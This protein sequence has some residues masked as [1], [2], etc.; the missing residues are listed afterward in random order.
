VRRAG[1]CFVFALTGCPPFHDLT[2][3]ACTTD[4]DCGSALVCYHG[5]CGVSGSW[6]TVAV[7]LRTAAAT[8]GGV[9]VYPAQ[10]ARSATRPGLGAFSTA[11]ATPRSE[12]AAAGT[13]VLGG[14]TADVTE[15]ISGGAATPLPSARSALG[16]A[17]APGRLYAIGGHAADRSPLAE[18]LSAPV[19]SDAGLGA[20][21]PEISLPT[22]R[23]GLAAVAAGSFVYAIGGE[24]NAGLTSDVLAAQILPDGTLGPWR[25]AG[26][27][28]Y[29]RARHGA[30]AFDGNLY[31]AAG[32]CG[33][34][35]CPPLRLPLQSD[36]TLGAPLTL[37]DFPQRELAGVVIAGG[38]LHVIGGRTGDGTV[39]DE[40]MSL[41][42]DESGSSGWLPQLSLPTVRFGA[43]AAVLPERIVVIDGGTGDGGLAD[44]GLADAGATVVALPVSV[45]VLG[46]ASD[47]GG[48]L[49]E[50]LE[51]AVSGE[52]IGPWS[53]GPDV[54]ETVE[55]ASAVVW[56]GA[57]YA[58]AGLDHAA[59]RDTIY[60]TEPAVDGGV[61]PWRLAG[62]TPAP[63]AGFG[64]LAWGG[65]L[66]LFGGCSNAGVMNGDCLSI[67]NV[68]V[69]DFLSDGGVGTFRDAGHLLI[70]TETPPMAALDGTVY[71]V[72]GLQ[73]WF[74]PLEDVEK[75]ALLP[76]SGALGAFASALPLPA[77]GLSRASLV[78]SRGTL[79]LLGGVADDYQN[80]VLLGSV[81]GD[82]TV[83][84]WNAAPSSLPDKRADFVALGFDDA[85]FAVG[86]CNEDG[87]NHPFC[88]NLL[89]SVPV[90]RILEDGGL[91][92]FAPTA[93]DI[94]WARQSLSAGTLAG[95]VIAY[96]GY[97]GNVHTVTNV[98]RLHGRGQLGPQQPVSPAPADVF[99]SDGQWLFS[100][101]A[102]ARQANLS[103]GLPGAW[104][105]APSLGATL[106]SAAAVLGGKLYVAAG[107]ALSSADIS[108]QSGLG[109]FHPE[110]P[111]PEAA[112]ALAAG[113]GALYLFAGQDVFIGR[114][115]AWT[116]GPS[117]PSAVRRALVAR[118]HLFAIGG[119]SGEIYVTAIAADGS[120]GDWRRA[121]GLAGPR[122]SFGVAAADGLL[123]LAGG[124]G[125]SDVMVAPIHPDGSLGTWATV[126]SRVPATAL[127]AT[128][129]WLLALGDSAAALPR[130]TPPSRGMLSVR[131][132]LGR[133]MHVDGLSLT[134]DGHVSTQA[135]LAGDDGVFGEWLSLGEG[136][137]LNVGKT[138]RAVWLRITLFDD[139]ALTG[140]SV[141]TRL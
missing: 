19:L 70:D 6:Q 61:T 108:A 33:G 55:G 131:V 60:R 35:P 20:W 72:G 54:P 68:A 120:L 67:D 50:R 36:G 133:S 113:A 88:G 38:A 112:V 8:E 82:S 121:D 92:P 124:T 107:T 43:T 51:A 42:L 86:G 122:E 111:L 39:L 115:T 84:V 76:S 110:A 128:A 37:A 78:A 66:Y 49:G 18:V 57:L 26:K 14:G 96:G 64:A 10:F 138:G 58:I 40:V 109:T 5:T 45:V 100:L 79:Y 97:D 56:N 127:I 77:P 9:D 15:L 30:A 41:A 117:L 87:P 129:G 59:I 116:M 136:T 106:P 139:A 53:A 29:G 98:G 69:A 31:V 119:D 135:R 24:T 3:R 52:G 118:D 48:V 114:P 22:A 91:G 101:G 63:G 126:A 46:G 89:T 140:L 137:A 28:P 4:A 103:A 93:G 32:S 13:W 2:G 83:S 71:K 80:Q 105:A 47:D 134:A 11:A 81:A 94:P 123:Y 125:F 21:A 7:D 62:H 34:S 12:A 65:R 25:L 99:A 73:S 102:T 104:M 74:T 27:L 130:L 132:D 1:F 85:V 44:G 95:N 75:I 23:H 90:A 141:S 17:W 16:A